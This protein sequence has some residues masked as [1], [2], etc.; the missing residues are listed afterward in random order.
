[1][2]AVPENEHHKNTITAMGSAVPPLRFPQD[3]LSSV[4][5]LAICTA[6]KNMS[7]FPAK[8]KVNLQMKCSNCIYLLNLYMESIFAYIR[9]ILHLT[10]KNGEQKSRIPTLESTHMSIHPRFPVPRSALPRFARWRRRRRRPPHR[11]GPGPRR[12][13][14]PA[15][16]PCARGPGSLHLEGSWAARRWGRTFWGKKWW[17]LD[18]FLLEYVGIDVDVFLGDKHKFAISCWISW[19]IVGI[20]NRAWSMEMVQWECCIFFE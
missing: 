9:I 13:R 4:E 8:A 2:Y 16:A 11:N 1:M 15:A 20:T 12:A 14:C 5:S 17:S 10:E 19:M 6:K 18:F 7:L 3:F